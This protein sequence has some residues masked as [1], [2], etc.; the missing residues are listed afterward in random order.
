MRQSKRALIWRFLRPYLWI[1][2]LTLGFSMGNTVLGSL[3]PQVVR[4]AVDSILGGEDFPN[5][6]KKFAPDALL[7]AAPM[8]QLFAAA[9]FLLLVAV[10][11]GLCTY[12][13]RMGTSKGSEN[14][15]KSLRDALYRHIQRL[16]YA[17]HV[18]HSTGEI[19]QRC[20]SDVEV[21][22]NFVT[23]QLLEVF[24]IIFLV[25][26][27][28]VV[29]FSMNWKM[30]LIAVG[31][32]PVILLYSG[33]FYSKIAKRFLTA[34]EAEGELSATVQENLTGVRVVRAFGREKFEVERF[35][36]KNERFAS[37]WI[38]LGRLLSA[39]WGIGDFITGMQ[40]LTVI[41][42]GVLQAVNGEITLG[43]FLAFV[44]YNQSLVW[45]VRGLGRILSEM[46]K[47]GVSI[48]RLAYILDSEP[49]QEPENAQT[50][51]M[52]KDIVFDHVSFA[53]GEQ[54][55]LRDVSFTIPAGKTFA[56]LGAT[57]SGKSTMVHLLDR[58][59]DLSPNGGRITVGGVDI[60]KISRPYLRR[61]IGIV[62][63]EPF[64]F[65]RTIREN[66]AAVRPGASIEEVRRQA[67]TAH[68]DDA[69][70]EFA[71]G[72]ETIVGERG[73]TLSGG[74]KQRVA[75]ARTLMLDAPILIFDDSLSAVDAET[76]AEIRAS[77]HQAKGSATVILISHRI[78]TLMQADLI[79]VLQDGR[80][81]ELGSHDELMKQNGLYR[82]IYDLQMTGEDRDL[83]FAEKG[84]ESHGI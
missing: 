80:V 63:Q 70:L 53:Y 1:F 12:G 4:V 28:L 8:T 7:T 55:V 69:I 83:L 51:P 76:D 73:V 81:A 6:V 61:N 67:G 2:A 41:S 27:S 65:S 10:L 79:L 48:E 23:N 74:Q 47:A 71:D 66:I 31:F 75:I 34:D 14:F 64:L 26:F 42:V 32:L 25:A 37:L 36:K 78:T 35:D 19:I 72:Y 59:Y 84:G 5:I 43:E 38:R 49:E 33:F 40:I 21:V 9:G 60:S 44:S 82:E 57:G 17:W 11:S 56:I 29:M 54:A 39:Y 45:P 30:T 3:T 24:R 62:L 52:D 68:V 22:R 77:L 20:T 15:V 58:L 50:P 16:P 46:S 13:S 18:R